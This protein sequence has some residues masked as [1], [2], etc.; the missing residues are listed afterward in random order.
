MFS[1]LISSKYNIKSI[2]ERG[3]TSGV[4]GQAVQSPWDPD[5][6]LGLE[7]PPP[8]P[9]GYHRNDS[10]SDVED[11]HNDDML[12]IKNRTKTMTLT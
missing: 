5:G 7:G 6:T 11:Q 3:W 1:S 8:K 9:P 4:T 2:I 10:D 12:R